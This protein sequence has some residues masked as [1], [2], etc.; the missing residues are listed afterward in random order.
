[1]ALSRLH[2]RD[3]RGEDSSDYAGGEFS[4]NDHGAPG[5][6]A[7]KSVPSKKFSDNKKQRTKKTKS[8]KHAPV[9]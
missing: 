6:R 7:G 3:D 2:V 8:G 1:M 5:K 4:L 9:L